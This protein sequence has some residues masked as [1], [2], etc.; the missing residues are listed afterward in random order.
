MVFS[1][2]NHPVV[3]DPP[4]PISSTYHN[5]AIRGPVLWHVETTTYNAEEWLKNLGA[6]MRAPRILEV[7]MIWCSLQGIVG[8]GAEPLKFSHLQYFLVEYL[9][10]IPGGLQS[11]WLLHTSFHCT[12][13]HFVRSRSPS[14]AVPAIPAIPAIPCPEFSWIT[15]V[16][17]GFP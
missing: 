16:C 15:S 1:W 3:G 4:C 14:A 8:I 17:L 11:Q 5:G 13:F 2:I 12:H 7:V 10:C 6:Y 9:L